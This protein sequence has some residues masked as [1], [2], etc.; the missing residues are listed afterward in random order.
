[1]NKEIKRINIEE[2][3]F[4]QVNSPFVIKPNFLSLGSI[5]ETSPNTTI[6]ISFDQGDILGDLLGLKPT[7]KY[8]QYILSDYVVDIL[9]FDN[10]FRGTDIAWGTIVGG[11]RT[12]K[13]HKWPMNVNQGYKQFEKFREVVQ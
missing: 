12:V 1:M 13:I 9:S 11:K 4:T 10:K 3:Y 8:E 6:Q 5:L 7:V 2:V